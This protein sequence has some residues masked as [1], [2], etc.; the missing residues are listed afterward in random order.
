MTV[1][2]RRLEGKNIYLC[3]FMGSGKSSVAKRLAVRLGWSYV[4]IDREV[5]KL[6]NKKIADIFGARGEVYFRSREEEMIGWASRSERKVV[7]LGGGALLSEKNRAKIVE[8]GILVW[9]SASPPVLL[10]RLSKSYLRPLVRP[11]WLDDGKPSRI[12]LDF[13]TEREKEYRNANF[14]ITTD[15]KSSEQAAD[16]IYKRLKENFDAF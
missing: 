9:L 3:G 15:G 5:E 6:E 10:E 11:E 16:E 7:S 8:T 1:F 12:F 13:L 2:M 4:D 14:S